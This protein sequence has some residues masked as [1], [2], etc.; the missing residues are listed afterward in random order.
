MGVDDGSGYVAKKAKKRLR[1]T[2]WARASMA[3]TS[4]AEARG[5][6]AI[7]RIEGEEQ[8]GG[9]CDSVER[10]LLVGNTKRSTI[11]VGLCGPVEK[12]PQYGAS[13]RRCQRL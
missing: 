10:A 8:R 3:V 11:S 9:G 2:I 13:G 7:G 12:R 5:Y 6:R 1:W 4:S